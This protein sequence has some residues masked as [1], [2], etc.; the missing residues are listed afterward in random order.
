[1]ICAWLAVALGRGGS[2]QVSRIQRPRRLACGE[3]DSWTA[4]GMASSTASGTQ[5]GKLD[6]DRDRRTVSSTATETKNGSTP[7]VGGT[8]T[9]AEMLGPASG[10]SDAQGRP[11]ATSDLTGSPH[12][13][14]RVAQ[15]QLHCPIYHLGP[16]HLAHW[17]RLFGL[18]Q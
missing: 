17:P 18:G 6:G 15:C 8:T 13:I 11:T 10:G 12:L 5:D 14:H 3:L 1:M 9:A 16:T 2:R 7:G 4:T